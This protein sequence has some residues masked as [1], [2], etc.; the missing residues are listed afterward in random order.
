M[1][2]CHLVLRFLDSK[3]HHTQPVGKNTMFH[4]P[5]VNLTS[6]K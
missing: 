4:E 2:S 1:S 6:E 3:I 5:M